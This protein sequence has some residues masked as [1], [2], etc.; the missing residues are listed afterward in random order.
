MICFLIQGL[1]LFVEVNHGL[2]EVFLQNV[3]STFF[4][5]LFIRPKFLDLTL[6]AL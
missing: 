5:E 3:M 6:H 2:G 1:K 4:L